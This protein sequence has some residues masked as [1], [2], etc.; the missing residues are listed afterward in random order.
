MVTRMY[1]TIIKMYYIVRAILDGVGTPIKSIEVK[2]PFEF[3]I[4][5]GKSY[6]KGFGN[7]GGE[8]TNPKLDLND[9][10]ATE[11]LLEK[12]LDTTEIEISVDEA[13]NRHPDLREILMRKGDL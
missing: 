9:E 6:G 12:L 10:D 11:S 3:N 2:L 7:G 8:P 13:E 5:A 1:R 4:F